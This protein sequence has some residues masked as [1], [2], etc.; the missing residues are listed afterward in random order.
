VG[1]HVKSLNTGLNEVSD[2][3][4][5]Y[6]V[7]KYGLSLD[8]ITS[9]TNSQMLVKTE[10]ENDSKHQYVP[11]GNFYEHSRRESVFLNELEQRKDNENRKSN[12]DEKKKN[13]EKIIEIDSPDVEVQRDGV[14]NDEVSYV[15]RKKLNP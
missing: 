9:K 12:G 2:E 13:I 1:K 4:N 15:L 3:I 14:F 10:L 7:N 8:S 11:I 6:F 5:D